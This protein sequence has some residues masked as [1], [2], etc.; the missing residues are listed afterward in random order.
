MNQPNLTNKQLG[1]LDTLF[2]LVSQRQKKELSD[3]KSKKI[4]A[5][6]N[7]NLSLDKLERLTFLEKSKNC[8]DNNNNEINDKESICNIQR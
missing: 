3:A 8:L 5:I 7:Y 1:E 6:Y 2:E 4:N